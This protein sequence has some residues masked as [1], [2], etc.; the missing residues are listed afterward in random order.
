MTVQNLKDAAAGHKSLT[1]NL[2]NGHQLAVPHT[3][4]MLF[5]PA[6]AG[7]VFIV[8]DETGRIHFIDAAQVVDVTMERQAA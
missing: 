6:V 1:I 2:S 7:E 8:V 3:D 5:L 4:F